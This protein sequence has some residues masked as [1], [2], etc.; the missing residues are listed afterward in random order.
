V[1]AAARALVLPGAV[2]PVDRS[3]AADRPAPA[4]VGLVYTRSR[5]V[6]QR[7][8]NSPVRPRCRA[9]GVRDAGLRHPIPGEVDEGFDLDR[10]P[11]DASQPE[12]PRIDDFT[13][14]APGDHDCRHAMGE[15][16]ELR[17]F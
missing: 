10:R 2:G 12:A 16:L 1:F 8:A 5:C 11:D 14:G 17:P 6:D 13:S 9:Y 4:V 7:G 15:L 3:V